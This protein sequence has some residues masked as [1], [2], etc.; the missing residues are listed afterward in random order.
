MD[1]YLNEIK[2]F[3]PLKG[4]EEREIIRKA[5]DGNKAAYQ[6]LMNSNLKF[7]ISVAKRYQYQGLDLQDLIAEGNLGLCKAFKKFDLNKNVKFITYGVWWIRQAILNSIHE[8]AK[9]I[10][11]PL[12]KIVN[13]TK[14]RQAED[15]FMRTKGRTPD[16]WELAHELENPEIL[17]DLKYNY[18][19]IA[20][21]KPQTDNDKDLYEIIPVQ[22]DVLDADGERAEFLGELEEALLNFTDRERDIIYMYYGINHIRPY[23]LKEIGADLGLTRERIRQIKEKVLNRLKTQNSSGTLRS[24]M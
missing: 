12:N 19:V 8:H 5:K 23:T 11:L 1:R 3:K 22:K 18:T 16:M 6:K 20:L 15:D 17:E 21:D 24:Y 7:V 4:A 10:R 14:A 9:T 13:V 2:D